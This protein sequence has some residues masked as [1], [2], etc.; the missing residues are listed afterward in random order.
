MRAPDFWKSR[1]L[2]STLFLPCSLFYVLGSYLRQAVT[3]PV[4]VSVPVICI[5]NLS[6]GG[7]GKTPITRSVAQTLTK[8]GFTPHIIT[9]GY[10]GI[11]H[12]PLRVQPNLH[13]ATDVGDE[14]LMLSSTL[15]T[16][17]SRDRVKAAQLAI[18]QGGDILLLDDGFQNPT[19]FKDLSF[20]VV[21]NNLGFGNGRVIPAGPLRETISRGINRADAVVLM[22]PANEQPNPE[23]ASYL[24][25]P[26]DIPV[27]RAHVE[28]L[29]AAKSAPPS[30]S[31]LDDIKGKSIFA[32]AAIGYP[33]KFYATLQQQGAVLV[34]TKD[35][36]DHHQYT[37]SDLANIIKAAENSGVDLIYTTEKD[38]VK[39][40]EDLRDTIHCLPIQAV[41][42]NSKALENL[43]NKI[44]GPK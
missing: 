30:T 24:A 23:V 22:G 17:V 12:G 2:I 20:I 44:S 3:K 29:T 28:P 10:G 26:N 4:K 14:P 1:G 8:L 40:P 27:L 35:F 42:D 31:S 7:S 34:G 11:E 25:Q 13:K 39:I 16:W 36:P 37:Q 6:A 21:D 9:R 15:P 41:W 38:Y 32:F 19:L 5:G 18:A 43:L 33:Q